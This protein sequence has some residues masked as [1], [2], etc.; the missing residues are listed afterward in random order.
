MLYYLNQYYLTQIKTN[1]TTYVI[2]ES[3][4]DISRCGFKHCFL[5]KKKSR[6]DVDLFCNTV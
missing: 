2:E 6:E 4:K 1:N 3:L 5:L